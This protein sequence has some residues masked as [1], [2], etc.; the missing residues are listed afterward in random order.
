MCVNKSQEKILE[1]M[2]QFDAVCAQ[3][4]G[5]ISKLK[6]HLTIMLEDHQ[7]PDMLDSEFGVM[8]EAES[9]SRR[10]FSGTAVRAAFQEQAF[11]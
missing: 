5:C 6:Q 1:T 11:Q 8:E 3:T 10:R 9:L 7:N 4:A 2:R